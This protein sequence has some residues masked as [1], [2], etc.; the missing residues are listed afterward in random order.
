MIGAPG[1]PGTP[2]ANGTAL[3]WADFYAAEDSVGFENDNP[4]PIAPGG[5]IA[6]P[7]LGVTAANTNIVIDATVTPP[8]SAI[9]LKDI[10]TYQVAFSA[11]VAQAGQ[12]VVALDNGSGIVE[13][14]QVRQTR[15]EGGSCEMLRYLSLPFLRRIWVI[16]DLELV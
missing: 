7:N 10:G 15:G 5:A 9:T 14:E 16:L 11:V 3:D 6:F 4:N 13:Q 2:G 12:L 1:T 8:G